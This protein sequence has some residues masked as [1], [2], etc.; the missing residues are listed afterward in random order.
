M[1]HL[2][3]RGDPEI[4][5]D[6][7]IEYEGEELVCFGINVQGGWHGPDEPQLWCTVGTSDEREAYVAET[8]A[9]FGK[10][11]ADAG[12]VDEQVSVAGEV[13]EPVAEPQPAADSAAPPWQILAYISALALLF[14]AGMAHQA[15]RERRQSNLY[16]QHSGS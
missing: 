8:A 6:A 13:M 12:S 10:N 3:I 14:L 11:A 16:P 4:R 1:Q 9:G 15:L 2:I 7:V 5:R